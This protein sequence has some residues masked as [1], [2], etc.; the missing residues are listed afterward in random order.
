MADVHTRTIKHLQTLH[1]GAP[2]TQAG[3]DPTLDP[4]NPNTAERIL[5]LLSIEHAVLIL[6]MDAQPDGTFNLAP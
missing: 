5:H 2:L 4:Y 3:S 1:Q 6:P